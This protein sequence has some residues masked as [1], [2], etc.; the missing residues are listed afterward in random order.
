MFAHYKSFTI[1]CKGQASSYKL[2]MLDGQY[3]EIKFEQSTI[4]FFYDFVRS[5]KEWKVEPTNKYGEKYSYYNAYLNFQ[6][7]DGKILS[8]AP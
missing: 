8:V 5:L 6:I 3:K 2:F 1:N 7:R 4:R